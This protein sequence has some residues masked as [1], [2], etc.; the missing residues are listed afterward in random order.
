MTKPYEEAANRPCPECGGP[1]VLSK[2]GYSVDVVP[3]K[4]FFNVGTSMMAVVCKKCGH[5]TWYAKDTSK[6]DD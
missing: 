5:T 2:G 6:L 1:R 4:R 3:I